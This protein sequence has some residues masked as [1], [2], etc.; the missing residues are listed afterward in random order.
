MTLEPRPVADR[1]IAAYQEL[2]SINARRFD[3]FLGAEYDDLF[4]EGASAVFEAIRNGA[5]P[6]KEIVIRRMKGWCRTV[7]NQ[8]LGVVDVPQA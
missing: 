8:R 5:Y 7:Q 3:G 6:S 1:E 4:Q 2:L